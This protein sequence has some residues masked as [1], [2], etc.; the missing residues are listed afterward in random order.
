VSDTVQQALRRGT[1]M[2]REAGVATPDTDARWL[3]AAAMEIVPGRIFLH[4]PDPVPHEAGTR[5]A[6]MLKM[7][8]ARKPVSQI[9]G[10]RQ[11]YGRWFK[12]TE[13]V[14]DPRPETEMLI[15]IACAEPFSRVLDLGTGSGAIAITLL[16]E[17]PG[18]TG[19]A[20]DLSPEA[21]AVATEN[22][23]GLQVADRLGLAQS[24]WFSA[25]DGQF[26]LIVSNPPYITAEAYAALAPDV[27]KWE[28]KLALTPG[29]D[30]LDAYR[31]ICAAAP[32]HL[33]PDGRLL[34]EIGFDQGQ[35]VRALFQDAG[36]EA[37]TI[38]PDLAGKDRVV[39]GRKPAAILGKPPP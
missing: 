38:H 14:L 34:V 8:Q 20:T 9:L 22:A 2:L 32:G 30:G 21:L 35:A 25:V 29:G 6:T 18:A 10:G 17:R 28:P 39:S 7:R 12:I 27:R 11:F 33:H 31:A 26:D 13:A 5:F 36:L 15:E 23:Q 3:L 1:E 16:A 37:V 24:D 4:L 19:V